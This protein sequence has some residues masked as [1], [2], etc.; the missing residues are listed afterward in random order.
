MDTVREISWLPLWSRACNIL[1]TCSKGLNELFLQFQMAYLAFGNLSRMTTKS[2]SYSTMRPSGLV[3]G[4]SM[5]TP[6]PLRRSQ[7]LIAFFAFLSVLEGA[8][9][10]AVGLGLGF[11]AVDISSATV[12]SL[13]LEC[14]RLWYRRRTSIGAFLRR[15]ISR[16]A[17]QVCSSHCAVDMGVIAR[18]CSHD[19]V[20]SRAPMTTRIW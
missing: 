15:E 1:N 10:S 4:F 17:G 3:S 2:S 13:G 7:P 14:A 9:S 16:R 12:V 11:F 6:K 8:T 19:G 20:L 5:Y 18:G